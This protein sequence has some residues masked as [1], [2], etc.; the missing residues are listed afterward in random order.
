MKSRMVHCCLTGATCL[1]A[2][3]CA[4]GLAVADDGDLP[5]G[6]K[7]H[8]R[9]VK[10]GEI[11]YANGY[12]VARGI[13]KAKGKSPRDRQMA[14]R[15]AT[16]VAARNAMA[17]AMGLKVDNKGRF[18]DVRNG[19]VQ[20][21]GMIKGHKVSMVDWRP[22]KTPP[23]CIVKIRVPLWGVKGLCSVVHDRQR[24]EAYRY[25]TRRFRLC[26]DR[27]DV[28]EEYLI[29]DARGIGAIPC[30][31]P[32]IEVD[33]G[34]VIYDV[35]TMEAKGGTARQPA[36]FAETEM[37]AGELRAWA[38]FDDLE[39]EQY[40]FVDGAGASEGGEL[41]EPVSFDL[42]PTF[43]MEPGSA[44]AK[45]ATTKPVTSQP[46]AGSRRRKKRVVTAV[47]PTKAEDAKIVLT[48][49]D[50][51][52]LAATPEGASLLRSGR[53]IIVVDSVVAGIQGR[54]DESDAAPVR[55]VSR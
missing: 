27:V 7:P 8:V 4:Q 43:V 13:G 21:R 46:V 15:G 50:A 26:K 17:I 48:K 42:A 25:R 2:L 5:G 24:R 38:E 19:E 41:M 36:R 9:P 10:D 11:D 29:I 28:D 31:Y 16:L 39:S 51:E 47:R 14:E 33:D 49:E 52:K 34:T 18:S 30:L 54:N 37:T 55:L 1:A 45:G 12:L 44:G 3:L 35:A 53:V 22:E 6:L 23:E 32:V 20:L 40:A